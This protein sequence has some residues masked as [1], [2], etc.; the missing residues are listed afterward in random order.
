LDVVIV[1]RIVR[2]ARNDMAHQVTRT[3][4]QSLADR[5]R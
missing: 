2:S 3:D 4:A 1:A 5:G